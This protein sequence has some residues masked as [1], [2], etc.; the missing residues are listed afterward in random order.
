M[1]KVAESM[2]TGAPAEAP[3]R[4]RRFRRLAI[5]YGAAFLIVTLGGGL[6]YWHATRGSV[7]LD[8]LRGSIEAAVRERLPAQA[9]VAIGRTAFSYRPGEGIILRAR[10]VRMLL[11][12]TANLSIAELTSMT[13][14]AALASGRI[15]FERVT[16]SGVSIGVSTAAGPAQQGS[17][18][19]VMR[20]AAKKFADNLLAADGLIRGAGL[21][22]IKA[23]NAEIHL[24]EQA[25][26][27][28]PALTIAEASWLP[29]SAARSKAWLQVVGKDGVG[30]DLTVERRDVRAGEQSISVEIEEVPIAALAPALSEA[31]GPPFFQSTATLQ[32]RMLHGADGALAELR[33]TLSSGSG[34]L[35]LTGIDAIQ[36]A[37]AAVSFTLGP[38]GDR[39]TVPSGEIRTAS[40]RVRFEGVV[41][42]AE[43][44]K[45]TLLGRVASGSLP[46]PLGAE[47]SVPL[48][49][50]GLLARVDFATRS[51]EVERLH[52]VTPDG[53]ASAIGQASLAGSNPG[54]SFALSFDEMPASTVRALWPPFV[55]AKTRQWFDVNAKSGILGPA[56]LQVALPPDLIGPKGRGKVLPKYGL[57]GTL[58][59]RNAEF[60]PLKTFPTIGNAEGEIDFANATASVRAR[61]GAMNIAGHGRLDAAGTTLVIPELGRL[62][63]RGDLHLELTGPAA[64]LAA[65]SNSPPLSIARKRGIGADLLSGEAILTLDGNIPLYESDFSDVMPTFRLALADFSSEG[66]IDNRLIADADLVLEGSPQSY[67]VKGEGKLDGL[68]A[69]VDMIMGSAAPDQSAVTVSLDDAA[70]ERLGIGFGKL[71]TGIVQASLT[72]TDGP[73]QQVALDLK[74]ATISL[75]FLGWEKGPG[76]PATASF[77]MEKSEEGTRLT[78]LFF[79]GTG[80]EASG[81]LLIGPDGRLRELDLTKVALRP[82]D[83][84]SASVAANGDGFDMRI[85]GDALDARGIIRGV[86]SGFGGGKA[87]LFPVRV[88]LDLK[89]VTGQND[90]VLSNVAGSMTITANGLDAVSLKGQ[91]N[92]N[93]PFEWALG[94]EGDVRVL[95]VFADGGGA[96]IRFAGVY[97]RVAGG[98]LIIDYS[99]PVGGAGTGVMVLRDFRLINETAL[100]PVLEPASTRDGM[101]HMPQNTGEVHFTQ[102]RVPFRQE[103]WVITVDDAAL[104]GSLLGATASGTVNVPGK[105]LAISGTFIPAFGINNIAGAIPLIGAI[106]GGGRDE[107][108]VGVTYKLFGPLDS[109]T[110]A[111]NPISAIAPGI[112]RKIFEYR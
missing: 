49:G 55:A 84:L 11:P 69:S 68:E 41:D 87:A 13:T 40:G 17:G 63:P 36:V 15:D 59:F 35:S 53:A 110:L 78:D 82:G 57:I 80:F 4:R 64:A 22:E 65:L 28:G 34:Q 98:S 16:V 76:V 97:S 81:Q 101:V 94:R 112:F 10:D 93:Q 60:S 107:G 33:G 30:W 86:G 19:D 1:L 3:R 18:A 42:L 73:V 71:V 77:R 7:S 8:F 23:H 54:L 45:A 109:P 47:P 108:L 67:T 104:R 25:E 46:T 95:R 29:L 100:R 89:A 52:L 21:H 91:S 5:V 62:Q 56:T 75:P 61:S 106:L 51:I 79:S 12:G 99:G 26:E 66:P 50:G 111:V 43:M 103:G 24:L 39:L 85:A 9:S 105:K 58:P 72:H 44:G 14:P 32:M 74:E 37:T 96:L 88:F 27:D 20:A 70:R 92:G 48:L 6:L 31:D 90:V 83:Q 2:R 38:T 102:L